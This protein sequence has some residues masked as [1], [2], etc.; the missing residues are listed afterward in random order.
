M[1]KT[2]R[3]LPIWR[4]TS[5]MITFA[6]LLGGCIYL[7]SSCEQEEDMS[8]NRK[9]IL[10][11]PKGEPVTVNFTVGERYIGNNGITVRNT[12]AF[13]T[14]PSISDLMEKSFTS[15]PERKNI[16]S[17]NTSSMY[18]L[19][20]DCFPIAD[21]LYLYAAIQENIPSVSLHAASP[22]ELGKKAR[23][24]AYDIVT[25]SPDT[26]RFAYADYVVDAGG[27]LV[28]FP[29]GTPHLTV[30]QGSVLFIAY[31][32][33]DDLPISPF[34]NTNPFINDTILAIG[35]RDLLWGDT[36]VNISSN[37]SSIHII[38]DH[39]FTKINVEANANFSPGIIDGI[40]GARYYHTFPALSVLSG[41][42]SPTDPDTIPVKWNTSGSVTS[43]PGDSHYVYTNGAPPILEIDSVKI[44]GV[45]YK[46]AS[47]PWIINYITPLATGTEYTLKV[48]F[49]FPCK[50]VTGVSITGSGTIPV[51]SYTQLQISNITP[52]D[53]TSSFTYQWQWDLFGTW[54]DIPGATFATHNAVA[55][56]EGTTQYRLVITNCGG[57]ATSNA[58]SV[59]G[60]GSEPYHSD[61]RVYVGA[62]W[63][64]NQTG[65]RL[66]RM[67][68][69]SNGAYD[70]AWRATVFVG[71]SWI[72]LDKEMTEDQNV[73]W[74]T[75]VTPNEDNVADMNNPTND[76]YYSIPIGTGVSSVDGVMDATHPQIYFRIG[77]KGNNPG[78]YP[79]YGVVLLTYRNHSM[80][81]RIFI[82]QG[83]YPDTPPGS[84]QSSDPG[85]SPYNVGNI[86]NSNSY[87]NF[88]VAGCVSYPSQGGW[89]YQWGQNTNPIP[90]HP[91]Y[92]TDNIPNWVSGGN[93]YNLAN[94]CPSGYKMPSGGGPGSGAVYPNDISNLMS[95]STSVW[96]FYADGFFDRRKLCGAIGSGGT[97]GTA[98]A[99]NITNYADPNNH[100][101]AYA[102]A[103]LYCNSNDKSL[104]FPSA[105]LRLG[106]SYGRLNRPGD[107]A[108]FWSSTPSAATT[109]WGWYV[110]NAGISQNHYNISRDNGLSIRCIRLIP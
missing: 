79:R 67:D 37:N 39:L 58:V 99:V 22:L 81:Q 49:T 7:L 8:E 43:W 106:N 84:T 73:G 74:R 13:P 6:L 26:M 93:T 15:D 70:G 85:W 4:Y 34:S 57:S 51:G 38:L 40:S 103:L 42:L 52:S 59:I 109:A 78:M 2:G 33:N 86:N 94:V 14:P 54:Q 3:Q 46:D 92:P 28:P 50:A 105:G 47:P 91:I 31:S 21:S 23:V 18:M 63:K 44:D 82:R 1:D 107:F 48:F 83:Q 100:L 87:P 55:A 53:A 98:V 32:F 17:G 25:Y 5:Y 16:I 97:A 9:E 29:S 30:P 20:G 45:P 71:D 36:L 69:S 88:D 101:V 10:I 64:D 76:A 60:T 56:I 90:V 102:G 19:E 77:L 68:R 110:N 89:F 108:G 95:G 24:I 65:E 11:P 80:S 104:F 35:S 72:E 41:N 75:D 27:N 66:I 12:Q 61:M 96:G 62:F